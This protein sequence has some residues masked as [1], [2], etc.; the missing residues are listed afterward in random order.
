MKKIAPIVILLLF[1]L[2]AWNVFVHP[3]GM[4]FDMHG[5][6][7]DGMDFHGAGIADPLGAVLGVLFAGGALFI[8]AGA[9]LLVGALL[10]LVF[11]GVGVL[12]VCA[13]GCAAL[14][15]AALVSPLLLPLLIPAAIV[16]L[17]VARARRHRRAAPAA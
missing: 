8:A 2:L 1:C 15:L 11:A 14:A 12:L 9:I 5:T 3:F 17:F 16:W 10:A 7:F 13:L 4:T 6:N